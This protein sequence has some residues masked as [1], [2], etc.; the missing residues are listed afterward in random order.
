[1]KLV[2][3][4][5]TAAAV[6]FAVTAYAGDP[7]VVCTNY[8]IGK[9]VATVA[10][11]VTCTNNVGITATLYYGIVDGANVPGSWSGT[12]VT[13][14]IT[15]G[16]SVEYVITA[17][18]PGVR[19]YYNV[20]ANSW[21]SNYTNT[22]YMANSG[23]FTTAKMFGPSSSALL[24]NAVMATV[25]NVNSTLYG[26]SAGTLTPAANTTAIEAATQAALT[27]TKGNLASSGTL[28]FNKATASTAGSVTQVKG[29]VVSAVTLN[30][31]AASTAFTL[32]PVTGDLVKSLT[33]SKGDM[34]S[35]GTLSFDKATASTQAAIT[36]LYRTITVLDSTTSAVEIVIC[37]NVV[38]SGAPFGFASDI[39]AL[40]VTNVTPNL[41]TASVITGVVADTAT[42]LTNVTGNGVYGFAS[43]TTVVVTGATV[44]AVNI[45]TN[46]A[47]GTIYG[48]AA[49][50]G[51]TIVTNA[52]FNPTLASV[53][54][55]V[56]INTV[57]GFSGSGVKCL[58]N[59]IGTAVYYL[60]LTP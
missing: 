60:K 2:L 44:T 31:K 23:S 3:T 15:S 11:Y 54:T 35:S 55:N 14:T 5:L 6:L 37:T 20:I 8:S 13:K 12:N 47:I 36:P 49:D 22:G 40:V 52:T 42:V 25:L 38:Q 19:Y 41:V 18:N 17:L 39:G 1:M 50:V 33:T 32:S 9:Q 51:A 34:V 56:S 28:T 24:S 45:A 43:D 16:Q 53:A 26:A 59:A 21:G 48:F 10:G 4:I 46:V 58:T 27:Q 30:T 57:Y 7:T 29:D